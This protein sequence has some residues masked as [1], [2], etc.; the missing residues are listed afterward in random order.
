M[1]CNGHNGTVSCHS[2][3]GGIG[4]HSH[5]ATISCA[6]HSTSVGCHSHNGLANGGTPCPGNVSSFTDGTLTTDTKVK[7]THINELRAAIDAERVRRG[8]GQSWSG[9]T[10]GVGTTIDDSHVIGL[11]NALAGV[12]SGLSWAVINTIVQGTT[13]IDETHI[14]EARNNVQTAEAE[15]VCYCNYGCTCNCNYGCTCNCNYA[16]TCNCNYSCTCNCNYS[17]TCNCNYCTC[18]CNYACVCNCNYS[19]KNLKK[20]IVFI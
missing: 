1:A 5:N 15:C 12:R 18:N 8:Y 16:C 6:G 13:P 19:D 2:H 9:A 14:N 4:C 20:D 10:L 11:R 3:T 7:N 17:C